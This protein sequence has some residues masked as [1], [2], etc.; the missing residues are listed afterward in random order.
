MLAPDK[1]NTTTALQSSISSAAVITVYTGALRYAVAPLLTARMPAWFDPVKT[2][3][4]TAVTNATNW[5]DDLCVDV[6]TVIPLS[7]ITFATTFDTISD[8][9]NNIETEIIMSSGIATAE[10]KQQAV[11]ALTALKGGIDRAKG[12][13][14]AIDARLLTLAKL[15]Q[16][17]HDA[18]A[19]ASGIVAQNISDGGMISK[20]MKVDLGNDFLNLTPNGPCM[21]SVDMKS[22]VMI[23]ITQTAGAHPE[24]LPYVVAQKLID[25]AVAD[26]AQASTALS[27]VRAIWALMEDL[28]KS[29]IGDV[30]MAAD[31]DVLPILQQA[32]FAAARDVWDHLS[33]IAES[34]MQGG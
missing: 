10:Q 16:A 22:D 24:L 26:N 6:T 19:T 13:V 18:M 4:A 9:I 12:D 8:Q 2:S 14:S 3:I 7:V 1:K 25:N 21:V 27:R 23:K 31:K 34:L 17:D 30:S 29:V 20:A 33:G 5:M 32:E 28:I 15:V 11:D